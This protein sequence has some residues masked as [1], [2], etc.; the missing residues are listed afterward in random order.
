MAVDGSGRCD[1]DDDDDD[2][3]EE[4]VEFLVT[5]FVACGQFGMER[6]SLEAAGMRSAN[7]GGGGVGVGVGVGPGPEEET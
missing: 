7:E 1:D 2:D 6:I 5:H 4:H 3:V